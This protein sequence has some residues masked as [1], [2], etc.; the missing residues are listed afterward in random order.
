MTALVTGASGFVG[1]A[2]ARH[3]LQQGEPV[4]V[5][6]RPTSDRRNVQSL[7]VEIREGSLQDRQS[8]REALAGC[9]WL[10]H[11]AAVYRLWHPRPRE[12]YDT[13]VEG[14]RMLMEEAGA[15]GVQRIVYTSSVATL[16]LNADS[17]P[18][19]ENTPVR[20]ADMVG[21]YKRSKF[22]AEELVRDLARSQRLPVVIVNPS[23][24]VG[25]GDIRPTPTGRLI[26]DA[27]LGKMPAFVDTGLN[28]VHVDDVAAGHLLALQHGQPGESYILGSENLTL[29]EILRQV[30]ALAGL[31]PPRIKLA[32]GLI[33]PLAH[34]AQ[35]WAR[36]TGGS[37]PRLTVDGVKLARKRMFFSSD[38]A[39]R[40]LGYAPRPAH[41]ALRDAVAWLQAGAPDSAGKAD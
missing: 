40:E 6:L 11:V 3:L 30:A 37:E 32:P 31:R 24:P 35:A 26:R 12:I 10:F 33:L 39:R 28:V 13:N 23:A 15:A 41:D 22:L 5:L 29:Q 21:H 38:R 25:P 8:L 18:G 16:G 17:T 9:R 4:R 2:V 14:T 1:S 7:P 27:A 19:D 36:L 34:V 20:L